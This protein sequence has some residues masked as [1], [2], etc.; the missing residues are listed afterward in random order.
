MIVH[1]SSELWEGEGS[2]C[3]IQKHSYCKD[4]CLEVG[5]CKIPFCLK[6]F[7]SFSLRMDHILPCKKIAEV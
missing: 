3:Y 7:N 2:V 5:N 4:L 6:N 1:L